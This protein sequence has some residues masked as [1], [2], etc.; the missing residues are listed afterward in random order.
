[1]A[2][3]RLQHGVG[4]DCTARGLE[5][6]FY[7]RGLGLEP[8]APSFTCS[9][10]WDKLLTFLN[11][12]CFISRVEIMVHSLSGTSQKSNEKHQASGDV[13]SVHLGILSRGEW[14]YKKLVSRTRF[15]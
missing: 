3:A 4:G 11:L 13:F 9:G 8:L 5:P 7:F 6:G 10:T 2:G 12:D 14:F 15:P 1:M